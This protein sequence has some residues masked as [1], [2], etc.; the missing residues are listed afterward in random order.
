MNL[1]SM[2]FGKPE[3]QNRDPELR[4]RAVA[5][6]TDAEL[7]RQLPELAQHD[8]SPEVRLAALRRINTE[9][10]WLDARL[11][12]TDAAIISAAD[13][14]L[15]RAVMRAANPTMIE[16]RLDWFGRIDQPE[17]VRNAA[18]RAPD[19]QLR[20][21][22]QDRIASPGFLGD[23]Y[24]NESSDRLASRLLE[25]INQ[26]STLQRIV[27]QLRKTSKKR[28]RAA[29]QRLA[30]V[31]SQA[32]H[33]ETIGQIALRLVDKAETLSR[34]GGSGDRSAAL[35]EL[36]TEWQ[37]LQSVPES[38]QRRF[39]GATRIV[40]SSLN[41]PTPSPIDQTLIQELQDP[42]ES[43]PSPANDALRAIA[44][45]L[46]RQ[47]EHRGAPVADS[48]LLSDW[49]RAWNALPHPGEA[50]QA[51][52][53]E[54]LPLL[55]QIQKR[56]ESASKP[57]PEKPRQAS[58]DTAGYDKQLDEIARMLEDGELARADDALRKLRGQIKQIP[59]RQRPDKI[60]GRQQRMEGRL[61]EMRNWQ[62]WS[63]NK[64]RDELIAQ[65]EQLAESDQHPDAIT[66]ALKDARGEWQ[67]LESLE[68]L[69]GDKR[70]FAAPP[71]QWR[72]FQAACKEAFAKAKPFLEKRHEVK[73]QNLETLN[74]F[75]DRGLALADTEAPDSGELLGFM[76]KA[77]QAIRRLD[78]LPPKVR[79]QSA[80]RL[81]EL[82]N[83]LSTRLDEAYEQV[84]QA[85][86][87]LVAEARELAHEKDLATAID[88]AKALQSRWQQAGSGRR[89]I[90]QQLW[91][92]FRE[93]IDPLFEQLDNQRQERKQEQQDAVTE[94]EALCRQAEELAAL[95]DE[96]LVEA[97]GRFRGL[98]DDWHSRTPRPQGLDK[99]FAAA[100]DTIGKRLAELRLR[101]REQA[102][103]GLETLADAVQRT[104]QQRVESGNAP[105]RPDDLPQ[106]EDDSLAAG[107]KEALVRITDADIEQAELEQQAENNAA[108]ARQV[109]VE[110]EFLA[111][112]ETPEADRSQRMD[113]QVRRL[114]RQM[115]ERNAKPD[116][117]TELRQLRERWYGALPLPPEPYK[118]L[119]G[120]FDKCQKV[121]E[122]MIG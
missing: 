47:A 56:H 44:D 45:R 97:E 122:S 30:S 33:D 62:H 29:E 98:S 21:A 66:S 50:E 106:V 79:G 37:S 38:L 2:L 54:M 104:W 121:L 65:V 92:E 60:V 90:E 20:A 99:R 107:L 53:E 9:A 17:L 23:C 69:P 31:S 52:R 42:A 101:E 40:R 105:A 11:R 51:L 22:A 103:R 118:E 100:G 18:R 109:A 5:E 32:G 8:E 46:R 48:Q 96:L 112:V 73:E 59:A 39:E 68:V 81:K 93:P 111:G 67:R 14:F 83:R 58:V 43:D 55:R 74:T 16:E 115:G 76:R 10:Y 35:T 13:E 89:R 113:Y 80:G 86:R 87:R 63:N 61:K 6:S 120:R 64:I 77:R 72:R 27:E 49:D 88:R 119:S 34:G 91:K 1:T 95:D 117:S 110:M 114:A 116:L 94:L 3:W 19:E 71:G 12:E 102:R 75:V 24:I 85:K 36:E 4:A 82:M 25:R 41:R 84:E 7:Q 78:D 15:V 108:T 57:E 70:R 26:E 28:A